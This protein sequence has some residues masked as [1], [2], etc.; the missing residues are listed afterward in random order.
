MRPGIVVPIVLAA[1]FGLAVPAAAQ[2]HFDVELQPASPTTDDVVVAHVIA[3][4]GGTCFPDPEFSPV[5]RDGLAVELTFIFT[6]ACDPAFVGPAWDYPLGTFAAGTWRF[7][8]EVCYSN[9]PPFPSYCE[10]DVE[11][12]FDVGAGDHIFEAG[13]E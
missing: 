12:S 7:D 9:T 3:E 10:I 11:A 1:S 6:D 4:D 13:F 2:Q 5:E 8:L